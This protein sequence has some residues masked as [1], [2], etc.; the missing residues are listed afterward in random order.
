MRFIT[1]G[2]DI[3]YLWNSIVWVFVLWDSSSA[4]I[5]ATFTS[6]DAIAEIRVTD[7]TKYTRLLTGGV[8]FKIMPN[9]GVEVAVFEG[10][11]LK[12]DLKGALDVA[13][14]TTVTG[15]ITLTEA[16]SV[17]SDKKLNL[18]GSGGD[19]YF[20]YNSSSSKVELYVNN[21]KKAEWG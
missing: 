8:D 4:N 14:T 20:I 7:N 21:T 1:N 18:E 10:D 6:T 19:T 17:A 5:L 3:R 2:K 12:T 9:D 16:M 11:T 13:G 15:A